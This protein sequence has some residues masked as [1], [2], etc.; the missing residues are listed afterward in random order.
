[1]TDN[2]TLLLLKCTR[3]SWQKAIRPAPDADMPVEDCPTQV[4]PECGS[5]ATQLSFLHEHPEFL[6]ELSKL[7]GWPE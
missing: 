2:P 7:I 4:C 5:D 3:C 1:M 6:H